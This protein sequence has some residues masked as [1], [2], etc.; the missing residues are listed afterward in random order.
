MNKRKKIEETYIKINGDWKKLKDIKTPSLKKELKRRS[1][2]TLQQ[3]HKMR[4][5]EKS[6]YY[7]DTSEKSLDSHEVTIELIYKELERR[8]ILG[9]PK[10]KNTYF[11]KPKPEVKPG[12]IENFTPGILV[13]KKKDTLLEEANERFSYVIEKSE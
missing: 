5:I 6:H 9:N 3:S 10:R 12:I 13:R 7:R 4:G 11:P 8:N 1:L 2:L